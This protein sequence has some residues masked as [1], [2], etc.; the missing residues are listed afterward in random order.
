MDVKQ[1][2]SELKENQDLKYR[3]FHG[4]IVPEVELIGVRTPVLHQL[5]KRIARTDAVSYLDTY[6]KTCYETDVIYGLVLGYAKLPYEARVFYLY[7]LASLVDNWAICDLTIAKQKW[8]GQNREQFV[9]ELHDLWNTAEPWKQRVVY[10]TLLDFYLEESYL[11][12]IFSFCELS[13][14]KEYYVQ[15]A[16]AWLLSMAL[17]KYPEQTEVYLSA[18]SL[19]DFTYN[20]T[21]QKARESRQVAAEK[22]RLYQAMKR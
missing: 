1:L 3:K 7:R 11:G 6:Q 20:K 16:V 21:L 17:V 4:S 2:I 10:V 22:K 9:R 13:F 18:C 5:A 19:D 8:I 12:L 14:Q 15:M